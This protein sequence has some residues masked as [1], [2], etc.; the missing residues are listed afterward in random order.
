MAAAAFQPR[1]L[2]VAAL[3]GAGAVLAPA[4]LALL[5]DLSDRPEYQ[6]TTT[7]IVIPDPPRWVP[8]D[9][10][11]QVIRQA[12][13]EDNVSVLDPELAGK[14]A[15]AFEKHPWVQGPV[16]VRITVPAR[17]EVRFEYRRPVAMVQV[18]GGYYPVDD[19]AV[20]LPPA[21]F[22]P[23]ELDRYP[24]ITGMTT[25]PLS[26][27]GSTWGDARVVGAA[28]LATVLTPYWTE[29]TLAEIQVPPR[30]SADQKYED[31]EFIVR[32]RGGSRIN[33]GRPPGHG[34]PLE[35]TDEQKIGRL[36]RF[37]ALGRSFDEPVEV[38]LNHLME[39]S[40]RTLSPHPE[41]VPVKSKASNKTTSKSSVKPAGKAAAA[42]AKSARR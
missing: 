11:E 42:P 13:L 30:K 19:A 29:W 14:L 1:K 38:N 16:Q 2:L 8:A 23:S 27:V 28:R 33:W 36:K 35:I 22:P 41:A 20:L 3:L 39:L 6:L 21:D 9:L 4:A 7:A 32:T 15:A 26:G 24:K 25:T 10:A 17:V 12:G 40:Y 5:P 31:L 37:L 18:S 34:H